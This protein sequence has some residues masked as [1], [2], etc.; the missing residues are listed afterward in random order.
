M[1]FTQPIRHGLDIHSDTP[2]NPRTIWQYL[3]KSGLF[4]TPPAR[5]PS[6]QRH[7]RATQ[8]KI[9]RHGLTVARSAPG[10][11]ERTSD[12]NRP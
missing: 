4:R 5:I 10:A 7:I 8:P 1:T 6:P 2:N 11:T 9:Q 3:D 12:V